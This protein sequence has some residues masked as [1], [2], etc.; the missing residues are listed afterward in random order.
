MP[1]ATIRRLL[2]SRDA[3]SGSEDGNGR[4]VTRLQQSM[5]ERELPIRLRSKGGGQLALLSEQR[6]RNTGTRGAR[7]QPHLRHK[8]RTAERTPLV[9]QV[10]RDRSGSPTRQDFV[11][12]SVEE[13]LKI[14]IR[15]QERLSTRTPP[16]GRVILDRPNAGTS[17]SPGSTVLSSVAE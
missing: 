14:R 5:E 12:P 7:G 9:D 15:I 11:P 3:G 13:R 16:S 4:G 2:S 17:V 8:T 10:T 1:R 6:T